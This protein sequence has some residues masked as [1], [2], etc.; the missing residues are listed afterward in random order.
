MGEEEELAAR[1][2]K[3]DER[4]FEL[5]V[6]RCWD[7]LARFAAA[8][9]GGD[10]ELAEE[11]AQDALYRIYSALPRFRGD[12]AFRTFAYRV[13]RNAAVDALRRRQRERRRDRPGDGAQAAGS[14]PLLDAEASYPGPEECLLRASEEEAVR[15]AMGRMPEEG[16][17]LVYLKEVEGLGVAELAAVLG[18]PGGTVKSRLSRARDRLRALLKEDGYAVER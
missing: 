3:G 13:C 11:A 4:A 2:G 1:A 9:V 7:S 14:D 18:V 17:S 16:R 15:R 8:A 10:P 5:L 6:A 12:S